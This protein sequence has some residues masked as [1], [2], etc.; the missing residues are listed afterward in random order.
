M[1]LF[2]TV[3]TYTAPTSN[4]RGEAAD[5]RAVI[6]KITKGRFEYP[7][8]SPEA[9]RNGLRETFATMG[10]PC[11]R[12]RLHDEEQLAVRFLDYPDAERFIDDFF[13]GWLVAA[14]SAGRKKITSELKERGRDSQQFSYKRDSVLRM[15]MA[16]ALEP[17]RYNSVFTQS[18]QDLTPKEIK[19]C[20]NTENS[21]LLRREVACTPFQY[22]FALNLEECVEQQEWTRKL[23]EAIGQLN[24]VAGNHARSYF[25]MAPASLVLRLTPRL[26]AGYDSY[27]FSMNEEGTHDFPEVIE[28]ILLGDYPGEEFWLGG[29]LVKDMDESLIKELVDK[30]VHLQRNAPNLLAAVGDAL[31]SRKDY[32]NSTS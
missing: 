24:G 8:I 31:F 11:N 14:G 28:G 7:I 1:N 13:M 20:K 32:V 15:N 2:C 30:G 10:L 29:K 12:E 6:Q 21:Q 4:Y 23:L 17:Y 27:G 3:L 18:P 26:V 19:G 16:V 5:N 22:P 25:E 9:V